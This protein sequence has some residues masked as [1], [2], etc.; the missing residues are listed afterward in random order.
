MDQVE[1]ETLVCSNLDRYELR[2]RDVDERDLWESMLKIASKSAADFDCALAWA[3]S[4]VKA[5]RIRQDEP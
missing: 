1:T 4:A 2:F 3:D 5:L